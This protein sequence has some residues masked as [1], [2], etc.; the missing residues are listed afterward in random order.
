M[1]IKIANNLSKLANRAT[2]S[3]DDIAGTSVLSGLMG[4]GAG[5]GIGG[6]L[7]AGA[8]GIGGLLGEALKAEQQKNYLKA[9]LAGAGQGGMLGAG[10]GGAA[11]AGLGVGGAAGLMHGINTGEAGA[12]SQYNS[13]SAWD[14]LFGPKM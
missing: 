7:G 5:A 8:G 12:R 2:F 4:G 1:S 6:L 3:D 11:G 13:M 10:L 9:L 14:K